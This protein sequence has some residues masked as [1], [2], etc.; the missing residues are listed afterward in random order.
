[1]QSSW[2]SLLRDLTE[3][4]EAEADRL[5]LIRDIDQRVMHQRLAVDELITHVS[6]RLAANAHANAY[7][8]Y[9][10]AGPETG[11][12]LL[13]ASH[14]PFPDSLEGRLANKLRVWQQR[15]EL[16]PVESKTI[17]SLLPEGINAR[18]IL[19]VALGGDEPVGVLLLMSPLSSKDTHFRIPEIKEHVRMVRDQTNIALGLIAERRLALLV[20]D[21]T[22]QVLHQNLDPLTCLDLIVDGIT[23]YLPSHGPLT[24]TPPPKA[25]ILFYDPGDEYLTIMATAGSEPR[26]TKLFLS[27]CICGL[28][29]ER[30]LNNPDAPPYLSLD[31][32]QYPD[33]YKWIL[34]TGQHP[35]RSEL[36]VALI[37]NNAP[38]GLINLEHSDEHAFLTPHLSGVC[39]AALALAP[40]VR[41]LQ[42]RLH[43]ETERDH[44]LLYSIQSMLL[45]LAEQFEHRVGTPL[46]NARLELDDV[47][48]TCPPANETIVAIRR[49]LDSFEKNADQFKQSL[50]RF[51]ILGKNDLTRLI[52]DVLGYFDPPR[53]LATDGIE[54]S[55]N[56]APGISVYCSPW[57]KEHLYN[58]IDNAVY[59]LRE[60]KAEGLRSGGLISISTRTAAQ[61][62]TDISGLPT[63]PT[64]PKFCYLT[65]RDNGKG[66]AI[67]DR[68]MVG[69]PGF[70]T[71]GRHGTGRGLAA[72][73]EYMKAIGGTL[74]WE[75]EPG[76]YFSLTMR[77]EIFDPRLHSDIQLN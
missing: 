1:M 8:F 74:N 57:L 44:S 24:I 69:T 59:S 17:S 71:K 41:A 73:D 21:V 55:A 27:E 60:T 38:I 10:D 46:A 14:H 9:L 77:F 26:G 23:R 50:P 72:A 2:S 54:L 64:L 3:H 30:L 76:S 66:V 35:P 43:T 22:D 52:S 42:Q 5:G 47:A 40:F 36:V 33:R 65:I 6:G 56:I 19:P 51:M 28:L 61:A 29:I 25:Q 18:S 32:R 45:R 37:A 15:P 34:N 20:H 39:D 31:P 48:D 16:L 12:R 67:E 62:G 68:G 13:T 7:C 49:Y 4:F 75:S 53:L 58:V 70:T 11:F 63:E